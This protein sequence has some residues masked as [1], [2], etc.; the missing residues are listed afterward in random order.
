MLLTTYLTIKLWAQDF[1]EVIADEA[2]GRINHHLIE[3][4]SE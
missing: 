4:E 2:E 1:Y 3:M